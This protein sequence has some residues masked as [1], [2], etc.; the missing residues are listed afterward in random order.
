VPYL[1]RLVTGFSLW[2][3]RFATRL[4]YV[5]FMADRVVQGEVSSEPFGF[6]VSVFHH[7][8]MLSH[9]LSRGLA[10]GSLVAQFH[11]DVFILIVAVRRCLL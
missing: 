5:V 7:Y 8:P 4:V 3:P 9:V 10:K 1:R 6:P 2:R 11:T